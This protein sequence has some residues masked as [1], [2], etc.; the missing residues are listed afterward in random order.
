[1]LSTPAVVDI[2]RACDS[3]DDTHCLSHTHLRTVKYI[4]MKMELRREVKH[5]GVRAH[6]RVRSSRDSHN[7][8]CNAR[9]RR[10]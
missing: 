6:A 3:I 7:K 2:N 5:F 10:T 9:W 4:E 8:Q 1:V